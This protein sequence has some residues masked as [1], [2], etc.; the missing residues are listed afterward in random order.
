MTIYLAAFVMFFSSVWQAGPSG[1][2]GKPEDSQSRAHSYLSSLK[3]GDALPDSQTVYTQF[4]WGSDYSTIKV[5]PVSNAQKIS[6]QSALADGGAGYF[7]A[8]IYNVDNKNVG[9]LG[10]KEGGVGYLW[11]GELADGTHGAAIYS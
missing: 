2:K 7:V 8:K 11:V 10:L 9:P 3:F 4:A 5:V 6:W 1:L